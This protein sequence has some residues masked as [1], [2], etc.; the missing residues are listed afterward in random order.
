M[1]FF[2]GT[3]E[4]ALLH[5]PEGWSYLPVPVSCNLDIEELLQPFIDDVEIVREVSGTNVYWPEYNINSLIEICPGSAYLIQAYNDFDLQFSPCQNEL[6][7]GVSVATKNTLSVPA[8]NTPHPSNS[9]HTIAFTKEAVPTMEPNDIV[10]VFNNNGICVGTQQFPGNN[11]AITAFGND[12]TSPEVD[13]ME[14]NE[15][16]FF[17]L[18]RESTGETFDLDVIFDAT[19]PNMEKFDENGLSAIKHLKYAST[20][21]TTNNE[22]TYNILPNPT[23]GIIKIIDTKGIQLITIQTMN[24]KKVMSTHPNSNITIIDLTSLEAGMYIMRLA[25]DAGIFN[26]KIIKR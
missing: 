12:I 10:G 8:W 15:I 14:E 25:G 2:G 7:F 24:G 18:Y 20:N 13:G 26:E 9:L 11:F 1:H 4:E 5:I 16:L 23:D 19:M 22:T 21:T 3:N 17:R 6:K